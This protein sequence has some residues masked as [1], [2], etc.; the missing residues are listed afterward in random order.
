[1]KPTE[2]CEE[3][4]RCNQDRVGRTPGK[5]GRGIVAHVSSSFSFST[6]ITA[7]IHSN[8]SCVRSTGLH[9]ICRAASVST[10]AAG[11]TGSS[12]WIG[13]YTYQQTSVAHSS[14]GQRLHVAY[15]TITHEIDLV[16]GNTVG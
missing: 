2:T 16:I 6:I 8:H 13:S 1:M 15:S 14:Y 10:G 12:W 5:C 3:R 11:A 7:F 9:A 4:T